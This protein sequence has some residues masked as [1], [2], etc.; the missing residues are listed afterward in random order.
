MAF[1]HLGV[2]FDLHAGGKDLIFPH[3]ENEIAQSQGA[4]GEGTF[5]RYWLHNGFLN[6]NQEK[7]SKSIGNVVGI[8][9]ITGRY[10]PEALRFFFL[11]HHY[12]SPINFEVIERDGGPAF[13]DVEAAERRLDYFYSTLRRL[14]DAAPADAGPGPV[15]PEAE[16][17]VPAVREALADDFNT[18]VAVAALG[19]AARAANK[20]LDESKGV[21]KDVRRRSLRALAR[22]LA[23]VARGA[24]GLLERPPIEFLT[25]R[26][27]RLAARRGIDGGAV[28][29]R[30]AARDE[31]RRAKDFARAD[32]L[33]GELRELGV[34]VLDTPQGAEWRVAE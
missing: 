8:D 5:A 10:D 11:S 7:M 6:F 9:D 2:S 12:R 17:L 21:A 29:A 20:L 19:E 15:I 30:L 24:L 22:D 16:A 13:V 32:A 14:A 18:P 27:D 33:R 3:H 23:D 25:A 31:A 1:K 4:F 28:A 34:E 26:R